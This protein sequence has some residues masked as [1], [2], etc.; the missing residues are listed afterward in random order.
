MHLFLLSYYN[1]IIFTH[2]GPRRMLIFFWR[3]I[4]YLVAISS[5]F[6]LFKAFLDNFNYFITDL[7]KSL[8]CQYLSFVNIIFNRFCPVKKCEVSPYCLCHDSVT[9][10]KQNSK[11]GGNCLQQVI[12]HDKCKFLVFR[13]GDLVLTIVADCKT[14]VIYGTLYSFSEQTFLNIKE[15]KNVRVD[16]W[17]YFS[18]LK[19]H[20]NFKTFQ[21]TFAG[22]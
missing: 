10:N 18:T 14:N 11:K 4:C 21:W 7:S 2:P 6:M 17:S 20:L 5:E 8:L 1:S 9:L 19:P 15:M 12:R 22:D 13:W 16:N 3:N